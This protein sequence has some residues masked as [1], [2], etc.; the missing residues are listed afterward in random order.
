MLIAIKY[1]ED[2]WGWWPKVGPKHFRSGIWRA[3]ALVGDNSHLRGKTLYKGVGFIVGDGRNVRFWLDNWVNVG[4]LCVL[5]PR[6]FRLAV[7]KESSISDC[8]VVR[9]GCM[10][11]G[12]SLTRSLQQ[13]K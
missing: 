9:S 7:D 5:F 8:F 12:V 13:L 3:I 1:G 11:W 6:L 10:V 2:K 4:P